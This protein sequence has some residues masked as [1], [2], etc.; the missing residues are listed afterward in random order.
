M[1]MVFLTITS[2]VGLIDR[3]QCCRSPYRTG[4]GFGLGHGHHTD[5][6]TVLVL[7]LVMAIL[8]GHGH[9]VGRGLGHGHGQQQTK[10]YNYP[11]NTLTSREEI[12]SAQRDDPVEASERISSSSR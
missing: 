12:S 3:N 10:T 1:V 4:H 8:H 11:S 5:M 9:G 7:V 6:V 2:S